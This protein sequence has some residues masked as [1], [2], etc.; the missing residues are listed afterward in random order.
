M[1]EEIKKF[2]SKTSSLPLLFI[3]ATLLLIACSN[4]EKHSLGQENAIWVESVYLRGYHPSDNTRLTDEDLI[5]LATTL[6]SNNIRYAYLFAGPFNREGFLP[7]YSFSDTAVQSVKTL[8]ELYPGVVILPWIGGIQNKTVFLND[9]LWVKN[10]LA[11]SKLLINTLDVPGLHFDFEFILKG[12]DFLDRTEVVGGSGD[13]DAYGN[14]VNEFHR[15]F[16]ELM[17]D[18]FVSSVVVS[19]SPGTKPWKRKTS[20][21]ELKTLTKYVDQLSFLYY[22]TYLSS[23]KEFEENCKYLLK[24]ILELKKSD[25][26]VQFLVSI[27][28]FINA[29]ELQKYRN[30]EIENIPNSL[31]TIRSCQREVSGSESIVDGIS[32]FCN[33]ETDDSEWREI[34]KYWA[35]IK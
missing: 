12:N 35:G 9:S 15:Q 21:A 23:Q 1:I 3:Y 33:W 8:K 18:A 4:N 6:Q 31:K 32:I 10:A 22:D 27:G 17:P 26:V 14:N 11:D 34:Y 20:M 25:P 28:T 29:L 2:I 30:M 7:D 16:R 24:D 19:T 5:S 13:V